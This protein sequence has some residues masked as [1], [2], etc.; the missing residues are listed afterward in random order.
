MTGDRPFVTIVVT[1]RNDDSGGDFNNRLIRSL[2]FNH[3]RLTEAGVSHEFAFVEWSPRPAKPFLATLLA[4]EFAASTLRLVSYVV[5]PA[6]HEALTLNPRVHFHQFLAKNVAIRRASGAF[7][8]TTNADIYLGRGIVDCLATGSVSRGVLYSAPRHDLKAHSDFSVLDWS[9]LEDERNCD[10]VHALTPPSFSAAGDFLLL[11]RDTC[12]RLR[13]FN[14]V[15][16]ATKGHMAANFCVKAQSSGVLVT[17]IGFPVYHAGGGT[18]KKHGNGSRPQS[19]D[20][21][22]GHL[23][24]DGNVI[25][26]NP[27]RWGLAGAPER[28]V[29]A[30]TTYLEF[31]WRV[32][33]P[34]ID[35]KRLVLPAARREAAC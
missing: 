8:L 23:R 18:V 11:D 13:G 19:R 16:R 4:D 31:D 10:F 6:Y 30:M 20:A 9:V 21:H 32:I 14:E 24:W 34:M 1:G 25:Y 22:A 5:D 28:R 35:L 7:V 17:D 33:G 29:D 2:R 3:E 27:D 15:Y 26:V 12:H